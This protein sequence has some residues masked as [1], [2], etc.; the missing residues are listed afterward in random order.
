M[1]LFL[2]C[3]T[4]QFLHVDYCSRAPAKDGKLNVVLCQS[5]LTLQ[6]LLPQAKFIFIIG[7][8]SVVSLVIMIFRYV[9]VN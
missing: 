2:C 7:Y 3:K 5:I 8:F 6:F 1:F 9:N 4:V